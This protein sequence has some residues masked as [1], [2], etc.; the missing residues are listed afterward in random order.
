MTQLSLKAGLKERG[1]KSHK[2]LHSNM[3]QLHFR[4]RFKTMHWKN[5]TALRGRVYWSPT[6]SSRKRETLK[7]RYKQWL[8]EI[9]I[10]NTSPRMTPVQQP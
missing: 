10:E 9:N 6:C 8:V 2:T 5:Y 4:D 7:S 3:K 1:D